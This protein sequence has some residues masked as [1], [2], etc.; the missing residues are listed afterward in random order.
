MYNVV[1]NPTLKQGERNMEV[2]HQVDGIVS[3]SQLFQAE[4]QRTVEDNLTRGLFSHGIRVMI[5]CP[6]AN[7]NAGISIKL[8]VNLFKHLN[9]LIVCCFSQMII[10]QRDALLDPNVIVNA[11]DLVLLTDNSKILN[12]L[13]LLRDSFHRTSDC[14]TA[15]MHMSVKLFWWT[16]DTCMTANGRRK[17]VPSNLPVDTATSRNVD[18]NHFTNLDSGGWNTSSP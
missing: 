15:G 18:W 14:I 5:H 3:D 1:R 7:A 6:S 9:D 16:D 12:P 10:F 11:N 2:F 4:W 17:I 13:K 8:P